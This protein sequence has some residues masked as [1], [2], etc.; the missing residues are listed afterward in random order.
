M[1]TAKVI[2]AVIIIAALLGV[3]AFLI[4]PRL[5]QMPVGLTAGDFAVTRDTIPTEAFCPADKTAQMDNVKGPFRYSDSVSSKLASKDDK[6]DDVF[7][8]QRTAICQEVGTGFA[9]NEMLSSDRLAIDG[10]TIASVNPW[11]GEMA[12]K[13]KKDGATAFLNFNWFTQKYEVT[14]EYRTYA[15]LINAVLLRFQKVYVAADPSVANWHVPGVGR[16]AVSAKALVFPL[17]SLNKKYQEDKPALWLKAVDKSDRCWFVVGFNL[18]DKRPEIGKCD[19]TP[20]SKPPTKPPTSPPSTPGCT[21]PCL[22][23]KN[24]ND[25]PAHHG[26]AGNGGGK[27]ENPGKGESTKPSPKPTTSRTNPASPDPEPTATRSTPPAEKPSEPV[28]T[29]TPPKP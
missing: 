21:G 13:F 11:Q 14:D 28:A 18:G 6:P 27:N 8:L 19:N 20:P 22:E 10:K 12:E 1:R 24:A 4:V 9:A 29:G 5:S 17:A 2:T 25:D 7:K 16:F 26:N 3:A 23:G 15:A